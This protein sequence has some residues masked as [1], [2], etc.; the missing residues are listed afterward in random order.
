[1][2]PNRCPQW[3]IRL[4]ML[5]REAHSM[6][7]FFRSLHLSRPEYRILELSFKISET[8]LT[9]VCRSISDSWSFTRILLLCTYCYPREKNY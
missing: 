2:C 7:S 4:L 5:P 1:M 6:F 8:L 3:H 9:R